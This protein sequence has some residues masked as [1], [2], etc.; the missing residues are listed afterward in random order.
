[1]SEVLGPEE[2]SEP[3]PPEEDT[4][5]GGEMAPNAPLTERQKEAV[6]KIRNNCGHPRKEE[7]LRALR[8]GRATEQ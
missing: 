5:R 4:M 6:Q 1:M 2:P 7:F 3:T 8:L